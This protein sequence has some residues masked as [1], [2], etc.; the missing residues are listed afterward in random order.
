MTWDF[1]SYRFD[2]NDD[3]ETK[4]SEI[5]QNRRQHLLEIFS[6]AANDIKPIDE[7]LA[8]LEAKA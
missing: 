8:V 6:E 4:E 2:R 7:Q 3:R 5:L 1:D